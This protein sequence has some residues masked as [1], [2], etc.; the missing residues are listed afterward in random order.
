MSILLVEDDGALRGAFKDSLEY[1]GYKVIDAAHGP[2]A[3]ALLRERPEPIDLVISDLVMPYMNALQLYEELQA[4]QT[5]V[6]ML[7]VTGYPMPQAGQT[8]AEQPGVRWT[9][10]PI[11]LER[12]QA[13]V[14]MMIKN[15]GLSIER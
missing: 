4:L 11:R 8:L 7:I 9:T 10:K 12:L 15:N 14:E 1:L 3:L 13:F 5:G 6:R 2:Q